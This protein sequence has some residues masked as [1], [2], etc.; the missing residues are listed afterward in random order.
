MRSNVLP[1]LLLGVL[2]QASAAAKDTLPQYVVNGGTSAKLQAAID[3]AERARKEVFAGSARSIVQPQV[4]VA[5]KLLIDRP[6]Q[7]FHT[8]RIRF[9]GALL[10]GSQL[11]EDQFVFDGGG[12]RTQLTGSAVIYDAPNGIRW[13]TGSMEKNMTLG[14]SSINGIEFANVAG[15]CLDMA[16]RSNTV[17]IDRCVFN[18]VRKVLLNRRC[19]EMVVQHCRVYL[20]ADVTEPPIASG[21]GRL[22]IQGGIY[23]P[24]PSARKVPHLAWI[25]LLSRSDERTGGTNRDRMLIARDVRFGGEFGGMAVVL[26]RCEGR[27]KFPSSPG[28]AIVLEGLNASNTPIKQERKQATGSAMVLLEKLPN[29]LRIES[30]V[31]TI[32]PRLIGWTPEADQKEQIRRLSANGVN[33]RCLLDIQQHTTLGPKELA[34]ENLEPFFVR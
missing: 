18:K 28:V 22:V 5:G 25:E 21:Y 4:V 10:D 9:E 7:L 2:L 29:Y 19:D 8:T 1:L 32:R 12:W 27:A 6:V 20:N 15:I 30:S 34:P 16:C 14:L 13:N 24:S 11:S 33:N 26:N 23:T 3:A 31:G 17:V